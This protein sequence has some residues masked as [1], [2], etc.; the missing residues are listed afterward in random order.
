MNSG[1]PIVE[2]P[3]P[4]L[5]VL[6]VSTVALACMSGLTAIQKFPGLYDCITTWPVR[7][8][9]YA[10]DATSFGQIVR[11]MH[12]ASVWLPLR[13]QCLVYSAALVA[14]LRSHGFCANLIIGVKQ[15]P[16]EGHAWVESEGQIV[17]PGI[18]VSPFAVLDRF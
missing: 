17:S 3:K 7:R 14:V 1:H 18:D 9:F 12:V 11:A 4:G 16:F 8:R 10:S 15:R 13:T 2:T 6:V 5:A